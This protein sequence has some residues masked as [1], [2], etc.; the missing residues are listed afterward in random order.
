MVDPVAIG[1]IGASWRARYFLRIARALPDRFTVAGV[2]VRSEAS[3]VAVH[4]EWSVP[5]TTSMDTFLSAHH[6]DYVVVAVPA[7]AATTLV[8]RLVSAG[9]PVLLETPPA[10]D[11][12]ALFSLYSRVGDAPVQ[13]AEQYQFQPHHAARLAVA[14]SGLIG[15]VASARA[16]VAHGY[17]GVSLIRLAVGA[18]F[19]P[20]QISATATTDVVMSSRGR[21]GWNDEPCEI[22]TERTTAVIDF[23]GRFGFFDFSTEQYFSPIRARHFAIY[24]SRGEIDDDRVSYLAGPAHAAHATLHRE[25]TGIDGDLEGSFLRR[26]SL[27]ETIFFDNSFVPARLNDDE[28][29]VAETMLR[30][31]RYVDSRVPFYGLADASQDA[32][33]ALLIGEAARSGT[34]Q[35]TSGTPWASSAS[36]AESRG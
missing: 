15:T 16:S 25:S 8:M 36:V 29:A 30:M 19:A 26:I 10:A 1:V 21:D 9:L 11:R 35:R 23:G 6:Y 13:V 17:H 34:S 7:V 4:A 5:A 22:T 24:G 12:D 32:Y 14:R 28:I 33:L 18:G 20:A 27:A 2:L 3:A 31:S